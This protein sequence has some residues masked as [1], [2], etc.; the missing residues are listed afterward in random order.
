MY[1]ALVVA[2]VIYDLN[3]QDCRGQSYDNAPN[4]SAYFESLQA[5]LKEL[6]A[7]AEYVPC[8]AHT[9]NQC[10][11]ETIL[12]AGFFF[13]YPQDFYSF[14]ASSTSRWEQLLGKLKPNQKVVK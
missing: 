10:V 2:F 8:G 1:D 13:N 3:F 11:V 7:K 12:R 6:N 9:L 14:L 5:L 4:M